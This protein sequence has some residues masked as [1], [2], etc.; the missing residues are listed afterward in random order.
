MHGLTRRALIPNPVHAPFLYC[1]SLADF[2]AAKLLG[3]HASID[4]LPS[5]DPELFASLQ[6]RRYRRI[7]NRAE[8]GFRGNPG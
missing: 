7:Q 8:A 5:L 1:S 2:F 6:A 3:K 4:E